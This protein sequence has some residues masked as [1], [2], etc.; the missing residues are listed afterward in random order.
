MYK[1]I[2]TDVLIAKC[3]TEKHI[4]L[5]P[6]LYGIEVYNIPDSMM[7]KIYFVLNRG[8]CYEI[9]KKNYI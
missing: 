3:E 8:F 5:E 6:I 1:A 4:I 7:S 2:R 9:N